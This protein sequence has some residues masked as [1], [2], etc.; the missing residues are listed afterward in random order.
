MTNC[1]QYNAVDGEFNYHEYFWLVVKAIEMGDEDFKRD[2]FS[3]WNWFVNFLYV[4]WLAISCWR[5]ENFW[6]SSKT[7][8]A[9]GSAT[10]QYEHQA[11]RGCAL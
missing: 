10:E 2:L 1:G 3:Y 6:N 4:I 7:R 5:Q 8:P 9:E 11:Q